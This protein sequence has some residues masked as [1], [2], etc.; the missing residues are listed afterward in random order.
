MGNHF[1]GGLK[2]L[3]PEFKSSAHGKWRK[4]WDSA[5]NLRV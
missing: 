3:L 4:G 1:P 5:A 2:K